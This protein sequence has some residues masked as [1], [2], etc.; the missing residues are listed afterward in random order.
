MFHFC[1]AAD[2]NYVKYVGVL[3]TNI[4]KSIDSSK[5]F[6]DFFEINHLDNG[7]GESAYPPLM[8]FEKLDFNSLSQDEKQE[9]FVFHI[10]SDKISVNL[11]NKVQALAQEL[12]QFYPCEILVHILDEKLSNLPPVMK[13]PLCFR[14]FIA[15]F[16]PSSLKYCLYLDVDMFVFRD[17]RELFTLNLKN[18]IVGVVK[19]NVW[20]VRNAHTYEPFRE[21]YFNSGFLFI[22]L[23]EWRKQNVFEKCLEFLNFHKVVFPDQDALNYAITKDKALV[24]PFGFN[25]FVATYG[26]AVCNDERNNYAIDY[27]RKEVNFALLKPFI[28]HFVSTYNPWKNPFAFV[29]SKGKILSSFWWD[30]ALQT[31]FFKDELKEEFDILQKTAQAQKDFENCVAFL[32]LQCSKSFFGYFKIPFV[33]YKVFKDKEKGSFKVLD[34]ALQLSPS[35]YNLAGAIFGAAHRAFSRR[36]KG[37]LLDLPHRIYRLKLRYEKYSSAKLAVLA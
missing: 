17:L 18:K 34:K 15:H 8:Q 7:G 36:K 22:N 30:N 9:G 14:L 11:Q 25:C 24:L 33:V 5:K 28:V 13:H 1:F 21:F 26:S 3:I 16:L 10:I 6:K 2:E 19:D 4:I 12:S 35:D 32:I 29:T 27:T 37:R 23:N 20:V 31:P